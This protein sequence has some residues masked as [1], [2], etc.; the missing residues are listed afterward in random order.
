MHINTRY[1][2]VPQDA[3]C[4]IIDAPITDFSDDDVEK[5]KEYMEAGGVVIAVYGYT[6][7]DMSTFDSLLAYMGLLS[8]VSRHGVSQHNSR[9]V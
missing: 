9:P 4:L 6:D 1:E 8:A 3:S 7:E 5:V 2:S